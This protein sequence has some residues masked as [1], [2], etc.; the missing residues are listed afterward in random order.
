MISSARIV[1]PVMES[2]QLRTF[3]RCGGVLLSQF[4]AAAFFA[5][6][7]LRNKIARRFECLRRDRNSK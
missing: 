1:E 6:A 4:E 5:D 3:S 7:I 2:R